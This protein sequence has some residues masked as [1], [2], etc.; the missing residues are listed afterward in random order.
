M[1]VK[2]F[3]KWREVIY[4]GKEFRFWSETV[5]ERGDKDLPENAPM[6]EWKKIVLL[7]PSPTIDGSMEAWFS[8]GFLLPFGQAKISSA[9]RKISDGLFGMRLGPG[10]CSFFIA[11]NNGGVHLQGIDCVDKA[12]LE[13]DKE[14]ITIY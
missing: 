5:D 8:M 10:D 11:S 3:Q 14:N 9:T 1:K 2:I 7:E 13:K 6:R 4:K 12:E